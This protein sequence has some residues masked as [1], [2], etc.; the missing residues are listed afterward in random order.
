M[1]L[2]QRFI[3]NIKNRINIL[4]NSCSA[5]LT[6]NNAFVLYKDN[7]VIELKTLNPNWIQND[8]R[9][10]I[11]SQIV[12]FINFKTDTIIT[13]DKQEYAIENLQIEDLKVLNSYLEK[14]IPLP[15]SESL[16]SLY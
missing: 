7:V 4:Q 10:E 8:I 13:E 14:M 6:L 12:R 2:E 3:S 5:I 9:P 11:K 15:S 16:L 1:K